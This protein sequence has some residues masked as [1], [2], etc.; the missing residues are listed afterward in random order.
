MKL[1]KNKFN[2]ASSFPTFTCPKK[3]NTSYN[4]YNVERKVTQNV[5]TYTQ[6]NVVRYYDAYILNTVSSYPYEAC[7]RSIWIITLT[8]TKSDNDD[9]MYYGVSMPDAT[10]PLCVYFP[11]N[12]HNNITT[13]SFVMHSDWNTEKGMFTKLQL[14]LGC[15]DSNNNMI[16][17]ADTFTL[18][19][20]IS[21]YML[22]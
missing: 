14:F 20:N 3:A 18:Q 16:S 12:Q 19:T 17:F 2:Y 8:I 21:A 11:A 6:D 13:Y 7:Y 5:Y 15:F 4:T 22:F 9:I 10:Y 1:N